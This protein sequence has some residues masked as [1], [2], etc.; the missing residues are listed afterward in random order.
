MILIDFYKYIYH[1]YLQIIIEMCFKI[2]N[3]Q[4]EYYG[5]LLKIYNIIYLYFSPNLKRNTHKI[6]IDYNI[7]KKQIY[8]DKHLFLVQIKQE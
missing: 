4:T 1:V 5:D 8:I 3:N 2:V 7:S 6:N